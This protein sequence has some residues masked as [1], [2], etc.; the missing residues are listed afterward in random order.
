[1]QRPKR[2]ILVRALSRANDLFRLLAFWVFERLLPKRSDFWCFC[3]WSTPYPHTIDNPRGIFEAIKADPAI[4]KIVLL[5]PQHTRARLPLDGVNVSFVQVES[6][7]GAYLLARSKVLFLGYSLNSVCSFGRRIT[8]RHVIIQLWHGIPLKRIAKLFPA[9]RLWDA[10]TP[11]YAATVCSA[12]QDRIFM[13]AAFSPTPNVWL[14]GLPRNDLILKPESQ[15]PQDYREQLAH[16][17]R[18][19]GGRK[20]ILYAPTWRDNDSGIYP[21]SDSQFHTLKALLAKH[22]AVIGIRAHSNR[23]PQSDPDHQE[24]DETLFFVN[25]I[26]DANLLLRVADILITDYSSIYIDFLLTGRPILNFTYDLDTYVHERGFLYELMEATPDAPFR[27]FEELMARLE[28]A[29]EGRRANSA[30]YSKA[31]SLFH[32]HTGSPSATVMALVKEH[33]AQ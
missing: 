24:L 27:T 20:L 33:A 23:R 13:A 21:F 31:T 6:L 16:L 7:Q 12:P 8:R 3:T 2:P 4:T 17:R 14:T 29:L 30:Q 11:K 9:E 18:R 5:K 1:M 15:L 10:E 28:A 25:D 19:I 26:P 32:S 22:Q